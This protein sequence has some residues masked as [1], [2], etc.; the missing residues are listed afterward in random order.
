MTDYTPFEPQ[1]P[2][3]LQPVPPNPSPPH[4]DTATVPAQEHAVQ[5]SS[6]PPPV[7]EPQIPEQ[8][9]GNNYV[10]PRYHTPQSDNAPYGSSAAYSQNIP[11]PP[12]VEQET[13]QNYYPA[14]PPGYPQKSR[15]AAGMLA[16][17]YG[18]FGVH[19]F[20]LGNQSKA[21]V[22]LVL[23]LIGGLLTCGLLTFAVFIW[24][25]VEGILIFLCN[26]KYIYD[27]HNV[28]LRD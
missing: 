24:G 9:A 3:G 6:P 19:N 4:A 28:I 16:I 23:S 27:G 8:Q 14:P 18:T 20:Y 5:A 21:V 1:K 12:L 7:P 17:I 15:L 25:F 10:P 13:Y 11:Q 26:D 2:Q 22:Q